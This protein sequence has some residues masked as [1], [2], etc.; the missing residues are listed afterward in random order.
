[1]TQTT[2]SVWIGA[3]KVEISTNGSNWTDVSGQTNRLNVPTV[4]RR[5]GSAYTLDGEWPI[6][7]V[8]KMQPTEMSIRIIYTEGASDAFETFRAQ[9]EAAGG[10]TMYFRWSPKGGS[11]GDFQFTTGEG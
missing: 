6:V 11:G 8:G 2:D 10:G 9:Y 3:G 1:M 7:K 5:S 4:E